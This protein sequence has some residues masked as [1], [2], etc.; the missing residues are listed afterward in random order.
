MGNYDQMVH[1]CKDAVTKEFVAV[2]TDK[3]D[4]MRLGSLIESLN[5][6]WDA[7]T[8]H[9]VRQREARDRTI[10]HLHNEIAELKKPSGG[11]RG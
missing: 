6:A 3:G 8:D 10:S 5:K 9:L 2:A 11:N 7:L 1:D 4:V